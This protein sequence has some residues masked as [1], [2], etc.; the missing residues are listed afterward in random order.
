MEILCLSSILKGLF[1][2]DENIENI[3]EN[4]SYEHW[5]KNTL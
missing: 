4:F 2:D 1:Y 3:D 5:W